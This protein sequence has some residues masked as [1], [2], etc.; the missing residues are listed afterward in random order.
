[1][2]NLAFTMVILLGKIDYFK[3]SCYIVFLKIQEY[4]FAMQ[5]YMFAM[6]MFLKI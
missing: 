2:G 1:M 5:K 4:M 6:D 3:L